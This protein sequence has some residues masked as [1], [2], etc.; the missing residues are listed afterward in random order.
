MNH[1]HRSSN[2]IPRTTPEQRAQWVR[3]YRQSGLT[4]RTFAAQH[5]IG[6]STLVRWLRDPA[7]AAVNSPRTAAPASSP[8][9]FPAGD[10]ALGRRNRYC[11]RHHAEPGQCHGRCTRRLEARSERD[12]ILRDRVLYCRI[13]RSAPSHPK[14]NRRQLRKR[15]GKKHPQSRHRACLLS[16]EVDREDRSWYAAH[17]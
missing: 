13:P 7:P 3:R 2:R 1:R 17:R 16:S 6:W 12:N 4:Q 10:F 5:G 14:L 8:L 9:V 15:R 11:R